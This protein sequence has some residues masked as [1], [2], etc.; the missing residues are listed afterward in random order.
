MSDISDNNPFTEVVVFPNHGDA[1]AKIEWTLDTSTIDNSCSDFLIRRSPD[2]LTNIKIVG[3][4]ISISSDTSYSFLDTE[5]YKG[6]RGRVWHYQV[7]VRKNGKA[8]YSGW[9]SARGRDPLLFG[10][11]EDA[12]AP[13][14]KKGIITSNDIDSNDTD[15]CELPELDP[16]AYA[17]KVRTRNQQDQ[18]LKRQELGIA[19]KIMRLERLQMK[20]TGTRLLVFKRLLEGTPCTKCRDVETNQIKSTLCLTCYNTG[21]VG[22]YDTP[23]CVYA[24]NISQKVEEIKPRQTGEGEDDKISQTFRYVSS[25]EIDQHDLLVQVHDDLR[26]VV[27]RVEKFMFKGKQPLISHI[28]STQIHRDSILYKITADCSLS[29]ID[30]ITAL[31]P[32]TV[33]NYTKATPVDFT[34]AI[35]QMQQ[36]VTTTTVTTENQNTIEVTPTP[37]PVPTPVPT[38]TPTPTPE[39]IVLVELQGYKECAPYE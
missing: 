37:T 11:D 2:G 39:D 18:F 24:Q 5:A 29:P 14:V 34:K 10:R 4:P 31:V 38:P 19:R 36:I 32:E 33:L 8:F 27:E 26:F 20:I 30:E 6:S 23:V 1:S 35:E 22:G 3:E 16:N 21:V 28:T 25:P 17:T 9:V 13:I 12:D 7:I 15:I